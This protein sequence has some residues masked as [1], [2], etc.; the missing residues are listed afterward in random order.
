MKALGR[1][2]IRRIVD[3]LHLE[4]PLSITD[5]ANRLDVNKSTVARG[6][7]E[8]ENL[9]PKLVASTRQE[10]ATGWKPFKLCSL[11]KVGMRMMKFV[12]SMPERRPSAELHDADQD[13]VTY[14]VDAIMNP[15]NPEMEQ[16]AWTELE[17]LAKVTR[18]WKHE[19]IWEL[20][21]DQLSPKK[22]SKYVRPAL[23]ILRGMLPAGIGTQA[24]TRAEHTQKVTLLR[25]LGSR[26]DFWRQYK[27][28]IVH[29]LNYL[30]TEDE[31]FLAAW[32]EW[33]KAA[34]QIIDRRLYI[35]FIQPLIEIMSSPTLDLS[36][37]DNLERSVKAELYELLKD[38]DTEVR[39]RAQ[40]RYME[41]FGNVV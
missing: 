7:D 12:I 15:G 8:L 39:R 26:D 18:L 20:L 35:Q 40:E 29:L 32:K 41:L 36:R 33:K 24:L 23:A 19:R 27:G 3:E 2:V 30:T 21:N 38:P 37:Y 14:V 5:L 17:R 4:S 34:K 6:I 11:T 25:I 31:I 10:R 22:K 13:E 16:V 1:D 9:E 28:E